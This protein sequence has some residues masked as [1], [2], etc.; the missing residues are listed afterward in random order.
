[1]AKFNG[2]QLIRYALFGLAGLAIVGTVFGVGFFV[3]RSQV[4]PSAVKPVVGL[5]RSEHGAIGKITRIEGNTLT[6]QKA[7][8]TQQTVLIENRTRIERSVSAN[9]MVKIKPS[10]LQV[11]DRVIVVGTPNER[12]YICAVVIR[13]LP[14][15]PLLTPTPSGL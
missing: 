3:G 7:N 6:I 15:P 8:G 9:K 1:M 10:D 5:P 14:T 11:G 2:R 13:I 12:G 4:H